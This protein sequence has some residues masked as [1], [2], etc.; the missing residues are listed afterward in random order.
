MIISFFNNLL[1]FD[2]VLLVGFL[3]GFSIFAF[4]K[5]AQKADRELSDEQKKQLFE[6]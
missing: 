1:A 4:I 6:R 3:Y 5:I 2:L